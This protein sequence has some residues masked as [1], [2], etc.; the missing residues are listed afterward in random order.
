M[1]KSNQE[2]LSDG[3]K[4]HQSGHEDIEIN[5]DITTIHS[6]KDDL[7]INRD[8]DSA[9]KHWEIWLTTLYIV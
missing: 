6:E 5:N 2:D 8:W 7:K 4:T 9:R 3:M 1:E